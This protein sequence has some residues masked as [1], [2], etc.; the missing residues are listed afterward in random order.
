MIPQ[1]KQKSCSVDNLKKE[2]CLRSRQSQCGRKINVGQWNVG[3]KE[4][5]QRKKA[6]KS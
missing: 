3:T 4:K 6:T 1:R 2:T 5:Q